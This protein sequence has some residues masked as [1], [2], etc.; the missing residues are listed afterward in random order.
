M[1]ADLRSPSLWHVSHVFPELCHEGTELEWQE[2]LPVLFATLAAELGSPYQA[3]KWMQA[4]CPRDKWRVVNAILKEHIPPHIISHRAP[5]SKG[6]D[7]A[8]GR[9]DKTRNAASVKNNALLYEAYCHAD[10]MG[11]REKQF[12]AALA[13]HYLAKLEAH[14]RQGHMADA[15]ITA[16][17]RA[18]EALQR[19]KENLTDDERAAIERW[20]GMVDKVLTS[21]GG[22]KPSI[23]VRERGLAQLAD[24]MGGSDAW[25][26]YLQKLGTPRKAA[27]RKG[28]RKDLDKL[29]EGL[30]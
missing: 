17:R 4:N 16:K 29:L 14:D 26:T 23:Y 10:K 20:C 30:G 11:V 1:T 13:E 25:E 2:Q 6:R 12:I 28:V 9:K 24:R 27:R 19:A 3:H 8:R 21:G 5:G 22:E 18:R 15:T 7:R